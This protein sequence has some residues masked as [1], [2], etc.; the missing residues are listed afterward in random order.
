MSNRLRLSGPSGSASFAGLRPPIL[1][2]EFLLSFS[3]AGLELNGI[4]LKNW[5]RLLLR[6]ASRQLPFYQFLN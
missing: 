3:K 2:V 1:S 5:R 4:S 6:R